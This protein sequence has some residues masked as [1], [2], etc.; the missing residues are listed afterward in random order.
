MR[1]ITKNQPQISDPTLL[2]AEFYNPT[3]YAIEFVRMFEKD[4]YIAASGISLGQ[5]K[6]ILKPGEW[7]FV[8]HRYYTA[9]CLGGSPTVEVLINSGKAIGVGNKLP[10]APIP[11]LAGESH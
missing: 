5:A 4:K 11:E 9:T 1:N 2:C 8:A 7:V 3:K 6:I 10:S